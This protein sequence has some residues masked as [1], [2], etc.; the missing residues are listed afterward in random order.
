MDEFIYFKKMYN[1][2]ID[3][4]F[5]VYSNSNFNVDESLYDLKQIFNNQKQGLTASEIN[6]SQAIRFYEVMKL[7]G[8]NLQSIL[9]GADIFKLI[10]NRRSLTM[11]KQILN[12]EYDDL[13]EYAVNVFIQIVK[14]LPF[15]EFS[16]QFAIIIFNSILFVNNYIPLVIH[17]ARMHQ[18]M[19]LIYQ[20]TSI[21][22]IKKALSEAIFLSRKYN[23]EHKVIPI[24]YIIKKLTR[25]KRKI[26][27]KFK[28]TELSIVGSYASGEFNKYSDLDLV[29]KVIDSNLKEKAKSYLSKKIK[30]RVDII[31]YESNFLNK[32]DV[33]RFQIKMF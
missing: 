27:R 22:D 21:K 1:P 25:L 3:F 31:S 28:I 18:I 13:F 11:I 4:R 23:V 6:L 26:A 32:A 30:I 10:L 17:Q 20:N 9:E 15:K 7:N 8:V 19:K 2:K 5:L 14:L 29:G 12:Q 24:E 33:K 16:A